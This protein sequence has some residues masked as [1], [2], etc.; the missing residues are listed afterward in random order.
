MDNWIYDLLE[1]PEECQVEESL[2]KNFLSGNF[3]LSSGEKNLLN[4]SIDEMTIVGSIGPDAGNIPSYDDG[5]INMESIAILLIETKG[6]KFDKEASKI[7][8]MLQKHIPQYMLL[9]M[10]DGERACV[11]IASKYNKDAEAKLEVNESFISPLFAP[12]DIP[13]LKEKFT[14][15]TMDKTNIKTLW[16]NYCQLFSETS[17][18]ALK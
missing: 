3:E 4:Y 16:D 5:T 1:L 14:L 12:E 13:V 10:T 11:S 2:P 6:G 15:K 18:E 7:A 8:D 9:G 17:D